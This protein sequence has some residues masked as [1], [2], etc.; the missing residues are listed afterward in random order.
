MTARVPD[1]AEIDRFDAQREESDEAPWVPVDDEVP[2]ADALEQ[3][4]IVGGS[5]DDDDFDEFR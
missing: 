5:S 4:V 1:D 3:H 2:V